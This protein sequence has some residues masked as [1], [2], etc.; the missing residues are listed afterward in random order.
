[1]MCAAALFIGIGTVLTQLDVS[2]ALVMVALGAASLAAVAPGS[3]LLRQFRE[4]SVVMVL[5]AAIVIQAIASASQSTVPGTLYPVALLAVGAVGVHAVLVAS[6]WRMIE[7]AIVIGGHFVLMA[8]MLRVSGMPDIDVY[9]FQQ[10]GSAALLRGDNPFAMTFLN[11]AGPDSPYYSP[12]V[13]DGDRLNFGF[14]YP[15]L[16]L[17]LA[18]PGYVV[19]GDYRYGGLAAVSLTAFLIGSM[20]PGPLAIGAALLVLFAPVTGFVLYWGWTDPFVVVLLALTAVLAGRRAAGTPFALGLLIASK[21]YVAPLYLLAIVLLRGARRRVGLAKFA[22]VPLV[23]ASAT[24]A[25]FLVWD[26]GALL[27]ST[28]TVHLLQPF[29]IDSLSIPAMLARN[30]ILTPV[31]G[32]LP[33][34]AAAAAMG[35]VLWRTPRTTAG[36][37]VGA[38][39]VLMT[40]FVLSKQAFLHYYFLPLVALSLGIA[41]TRWMAEPEEPIGVGG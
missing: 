18:I 32:W 27:Y 8:I 39:V 41:A 28:I 29:R 23:V 22:S 19:A 1:M 40:F 12:E 37:C 9:R 6:R 4:R 7:L 10:E 16:S 38:V 25:P 13:L 17:L 26:A 14:I 31:P 35:V 11:T 36:F 34:I 33:F 30:G 21:Q 15:P 20:R 5:V 2:T 3:W 24:I